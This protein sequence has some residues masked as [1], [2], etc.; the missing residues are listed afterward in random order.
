[1]TA[2]SA[3][4]VLAI[5]L[6]LASAGCNRLVRTPSMIVGPISGAPSAVVFDRLI[7]SAQAQGYTL[8]DTDVARG[9]F[10]AASRTTPEHSLSVQCYADGHV[11][12]EPA[13]PRIRRRGDQGFGAPR[14]LREEQVSFARALAAHAGVARAP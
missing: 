1:V 11:M 14:A 6:T 13:G 4:V 8:I 12:I 5:A 3:S 2:R 9:V 10:R 7:R